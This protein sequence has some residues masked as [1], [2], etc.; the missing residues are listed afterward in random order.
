MEKR[1][2]LQ[3]YF[4]YGE[5][6]PGQEELVD[7]ILAGQDV[8]G[9]M[10][11]G[12]GKSICYQLPGLMLPGVTLVISPL[13]SLMHDQVM[14]LKAAGIPGAY[15]NSSLSFPQLRAVYR[16]M[17][18]G[19]YKIIYVAPE[20]LQSEGFLDAVM[21]MNI[22]MVAADEAHCISQ[23][24]QD[25]RPSYL[26]IVEFIRRLP[27][28]PVIAAFTAT[29][30]GKVRQDVKRILELRSP[31]E[32]VTGFDRPNLWF[33][34]RH[35]ELKEAELLKLLEKRKGRSGIIYCA[36]RKSVEHICE[37]LSD[38]GWAATRYHAGLEEAERMANQDAFLYDEKTIM[39]AT[40]AFGMGIDKSN[41]SFVIHYN[42]PKS[43]EAYYQEAGRA[44]R[45]GANAD[46]ILLY[47]SR[48]VQTA[49]FFIENGSDNEDLT[50]DQRELIKRQ[51]YER[52]EAMVTYCKTR[53]CLRGW[54]LEYFGQKHPEVCGNCGSC[55]KEYE[56]KD[57]TKE[58]QMILSCIRRIRDHLGY[59]VGKPTVVRVLQGIREKK[60]LELNL[61]ELSTFGLMK[62]MGR[63]DINLMIDQLVDGGYLT[64]E[65]EHQT[66]RPTEKTNKVLY[67]GERVEILVLKEEKLLPIGDDGMTEDEREL[68][69]L[70]RQCRSAL[71]REYGV[72]PFM[73]FSNA[74]LMDM[75][76]K[77]PTNMTG[78][79]RVSGVGEMKASWYGKEFLKVLKKTVDK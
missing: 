78:F 35:P 72:A 18:A 9:I 45:D 67:F 44:G 68:F 5:F 10:P 15:V 55:A 75:A 60:I 29:A 65:L 40:N 11:T 46:C 53:T 71:A 57:I 74:T 7:G 43:L 6:R 64:T 77:R 2:L 79:K 12:G 19:K 47:G 76:K 31:V 48:D 49:R 73:I 51:D 33:E 52:L 26:R 56:K 69:D 27:R 66:L 13:I 28:R 70:L 22:S 36:T 62:N 39:V 20:R 32:V 34:V 23:W 24:G 17:L 58:A 50:D 54:I 63:T 1:A 59:Y 8:F 3:H 30:T 21:Q 4:G 38:R 41:V 37:Y 16:N 61:Q 42:M 25:F 14:A